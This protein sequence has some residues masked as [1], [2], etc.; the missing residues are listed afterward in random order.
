MPHSN[1][2]SYAAFTLLQVSSNRARRVSSVDSLGI[3]TLVPLFLFV[4]DFSFDSVDYILEHIKY[5]LF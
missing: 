1:H 3:T 5:S 4:V 2:A